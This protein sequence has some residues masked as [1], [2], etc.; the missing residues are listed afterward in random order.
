[1]PEPRGVVFAGPC[2]SRLDA[3]ARA[4]RLGGLELRPPA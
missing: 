2:L 4:R 1:M 3:A